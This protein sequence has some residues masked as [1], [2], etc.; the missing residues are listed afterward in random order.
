MPDLEP[1]SRRDF[2]TALR[3]FLRDRRSHKPPT[4]PW[5]SPDFRSW[6][7]RRA[8]R[9]AQRGADVD[10]A[11]VRDVLERNQEFTVEPYGVEMMKAAG[12]RCTMAASSKFI[13]STDDSTV[14]SEPD[15]R[16][17]SA[18]CTRDDAGRVTNLAHEDCV[19]R[20]QRRL[21]SRRL[22]VRR[23][24]ARTVGRFPPCHF[25]VRFSRIRDERRV[26]AGRLHSGP[27]AWPLPALQIGAG[28]HALA[29]MCRR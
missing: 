25:R 27:T 11:A 4:I 2:A 22:R 23:C 12:R 1:F 28:M 9:P 3:S 16:L 29:G 18:A 24:H 10:G 6:P 19:R 14:Y 15:K 17:L 13:L 20:G 8:P 26:R 7:E 5:P 21:S